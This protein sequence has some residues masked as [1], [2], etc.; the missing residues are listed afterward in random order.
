MFQ[1][2]K[3]AIVLSVSD[4]SKTKV[5]LY[6]QGNLIINLLELKF[7]PNNWYIDDNIW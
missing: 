5:K 7:D 4:E 1:E 6:A 3:N 2:P